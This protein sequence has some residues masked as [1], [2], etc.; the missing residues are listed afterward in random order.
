MDD[1][2]RQ[3]LEALLDGS[4][5]PLNPG[6]EEL[7]DILRVMHQVAVIGISRD[8]AKAARRVPAFLSARGAT[9]LPVNPFADR[10]F[11]RTAYDSL[12]DMVRHYTNPAQRLSNF[13]TSY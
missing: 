10:I 12:E 2:V 6:P 3:R 13:C 7:V 5:D 9:I 1:R 8:P 11:G 4:S